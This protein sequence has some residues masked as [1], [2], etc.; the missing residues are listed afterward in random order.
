[1]KELGFGDSAPRIWYVFLMPAGTSADAVNRIQ[2]AFAKALADP[3]IQA[4]LSARRLHHRDPD[5]SRSRGLPQGRGDTLEEGGAGQRDH[6]L[7]LMQPGPRCAVASRRRRPRFAV[8][9]L[10]PVRCPPAFVARRAFSMSARWYLA[11]SSPQTWNAVSER[12]A[13][14]ALYA[15][16]CV[17]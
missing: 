11:R 16:D 5:V 1:M 14:L 10:T 7:E 4:N 3:A 2:D 8:R 9:R 17:A 13:M 12:F 6:E 15:A